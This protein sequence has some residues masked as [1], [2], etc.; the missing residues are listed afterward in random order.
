MTKI[1]LILAVFLSNLLIAAEIRIL[2]PSA[3]FTVTYQPLAFNG[4]DQIYT[5]TKVTIAFNGE[6]YLSRVLNGNSNAPE[7]GLADLFEVDKYGRFSFDEGTSDALKTKVT[8][9]FT[10]TNIDSFMYCTI[11]HKRL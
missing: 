9:F 1:I 7:Y 2:E 11:S 4:D 3:R 6:I 8:D 5:D 10:K